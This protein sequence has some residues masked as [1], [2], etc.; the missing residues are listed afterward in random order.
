MQEHVMVRSPLLCDESSRSALV[1]LVLGP[2]VQFLVF[3]QRRLVTVFPVAVRATVQLLFGV[4]QLV[5]LEVSGPAEALVA[6]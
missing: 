5:S 3:L 2:C 1:A 4:D 6:V